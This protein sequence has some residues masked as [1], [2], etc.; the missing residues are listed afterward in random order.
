MSEASNSETSAEPRHLHFGGLL[1]MTLQAYLS[2][3]LVAVAL[4]AIVMMPWVLVRY[5]VPA[6]AYD[7]AGQYVDPDQATAAQLWSLG[8]SMLGLI[9]GFVLTGALT[10]LTLQQLQD[11]PTGRTE[12]F[13]KGL[14]AMLR[15][16]QSGLLVGFRVVRSAMLLVVP[17]ILEA[18]RLFVAVPASVIEGAAPDQALDRSDKL[19]E[20]SRGTILAVWFAVSLA[21]FAIPFAFDFVYAVASETGELPIWIEVAVRII[22]QPLPAMVAA[23]AYFQLRTLK[24]HVDPDEIP[25]VFD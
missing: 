16:I 7:A 1:S 4:G 10:H 18:A 21:L 5:L 24:E 6:I 12:S 15:T 17:G 23:V 25:E 20:G 8:A 2:N 13:A 3:L 19:T 22:A 9:L 14:S 11:M